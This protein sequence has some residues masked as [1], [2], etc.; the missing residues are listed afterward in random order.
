[1][2]FVLIFGKACL[3]LRKTRRKSSSGIALPFLSE[4]GNGG[5][6][7]FDEK[8]DEEDGFQGIAPELFVALEFHEV[9]SGAF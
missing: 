3:F 4:S 6:Q 1:M 7:R 9:S 5:E 2:L 8:D